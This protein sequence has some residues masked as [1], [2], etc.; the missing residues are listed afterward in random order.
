MI[1]DKEIEKGIRNKALFSVF[2]P[3]TVRKRHGTA[4]RTCLAPATTTES[5]ISLTTASPRNQAT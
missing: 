1:V 4:V 2:Q 5:S 3:I